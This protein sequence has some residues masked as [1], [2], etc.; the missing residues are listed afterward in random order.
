M[1]RTAALCLLI[2]LLILVSG[3]AVF[4]SPDD[5]ARLSSGERWSFND[6]RVVK[7]MPLQAKS[8]VAIQF[9]DAG[10]AI[11]EVNARQAAMQDL[12]LLHLNFSGRSDVLALIVSW[13][14][15]ASGGRL[16]YRRVGVSPGRS[17]WLDMSQERGWTSPA[18]TLAVILLGPPGGKVVL[19]SLEILPAVFP[20]SLYA[21]LGEW[22]SFTPWQHS[23][24]NSHIGVTSPATTPLP[25]L[26]I[27]ALFTVAVLVYLVGVFAFR[28][29]LRFQW[30]VIGLL[31]LLGWLMLDFFWQGR[32]LRQ[33]ELTHDTLAGKTPAAKRQ[34]GMD[35]DLYNLT[36]AV[37]DA[38]DG[39]DARI[40]VSSASDYSGMRGA[41]YLYPQN[42]FWQRHAKSLPDPQYMQVGDYVLLLQPT[43][44]IFDA[45]GN[46]LRYGEMKRLKVR[47][48]LSSDIGSLYQVI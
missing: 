11:I 14:N 25:V 35:S 9:D 12:P 41:Y 21:T 17:L 26:A 10:Q 46:H 48:L 19:Q 24:I 47:L 13:R 22:R 30:P 45:S 38:I 1:L 28:K 40:L 33:A 27:M 18:G 37:H 36:R 2:G 32:L 34:L 7:G 31:F 43:P 44:V 15:E 6:I 5:E 20:H 16:L 39:G 42:V 4:G 3:L 23:S 29:R 8:A